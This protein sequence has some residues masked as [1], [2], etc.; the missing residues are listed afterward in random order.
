MSEE[1]HVA[2]FFFYNLYSYSLIPV[3][4]VQG[5]IILGEVSKS[6]TLFL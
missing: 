4:F 2:S 6:G 3:F 1:M 5:Y